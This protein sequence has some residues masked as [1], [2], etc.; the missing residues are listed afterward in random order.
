[1]LVASK[2]RKDRNPRILEA[3][4]TL[5]QDDSDLTMNISNARAIG[6][7]CVPGLVRRTCL[8]VS[9]SFLYNCRSPSAESLPA[10]FCPYTS[11]SSLLC[12]SLEVTG[13]YWAHGSTSQKAKSR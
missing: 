3:A 12:V 4:V 11:Y 6:V 5:L 9:S 10:G 1:M 2:K 13:H 8:I 7:C